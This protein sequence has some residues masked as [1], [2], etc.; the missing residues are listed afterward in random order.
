M[1]LFCYLVKRVCIRSDL[2]PMGYLNWAHLKDMMIEVIKM[3]RKR[4][5]FGFGAKSKESAIF[6]QYSATA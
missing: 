3:I 6:G 2:F 4:L 1:I 5:K